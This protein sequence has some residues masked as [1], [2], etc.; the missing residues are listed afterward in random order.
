ME[1]DPGGP[2]ACGSGTLV[3]TDERNKTKNIPA[4]ILLS[5]YFKKYRKFHFLL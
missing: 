5:P 2:K 1:P 4:K 3:L